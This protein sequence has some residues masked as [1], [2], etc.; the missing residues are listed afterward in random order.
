MSRQ[1]EL[2]RIVALP[3]DHPLRFLRLYGSGNIQVLPQIATAE[4]RTLLFQL[5]HPFGTDL[6]ACAETN[7]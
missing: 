2:E 5:R 4:A 1:Q 7:S 6:A 3:K